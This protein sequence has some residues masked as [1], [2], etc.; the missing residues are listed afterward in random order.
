MPAKT[1]A[2]LVE[3]NKSVPKKFRVYVKIAS[4][5]KF[6][7]RASYADSDGQ[8][9][10]QSS[11]LR[12]KYY[13]TKIHYSVQGYQPET[14]GS[15]R[16]LNEPESKK[17]LFPWGSVSCKTNYEKEKF[18]CH[19]AWFISVSEAAQGYGPMLYDCLL[20]TLSA[21]GIGIAPD[22]S[23]VSSQASK[24][25]LR[26]YED[27]PDVDSKQMTIKKAD[28][29]HNNEED[30]WSDHRHVPAWNT[31]MKRPG[32]RSHNYHELKQK[33]DKVV[34]AVNSAYFDKGITVVSDLEKAGLL[35]KMP[36][37]ISTDESVLRVYNTLLH[38]I[39]LPERR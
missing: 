4:E 2:D 30:C 19:N 24:I 9:I 29:T 18:H 31:W 7:V 21:H 1:V 16:R 8:V 10:L 14:E 20:V 12:E 38:D 3:F 26:Y 32:T 28:D 37:T 33:R 39:Y 17:P 25:W 22:R 5:G 15:L 34:T 23:L 11:P 6:K 27:R 13:G 35:I 36:L